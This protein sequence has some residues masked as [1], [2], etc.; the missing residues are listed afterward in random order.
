MHGGPGLLS[1][2]Q[3]LRGMEDNIRQLQANEARR[4][5]SVSD[6]STVTWLTYGGG[7]AYGRFTVNYYGKGEI[8]GHAARSGDSGC[9]WESEEPRRRYALPLRDEFYLKG[10]GYTNEDFAAV[11][12]RTAGRSFATFFSKY[13][14]GTEELDYDAFLRHAGLRLVDGK[15]VDLPEVTTAQRRS[16][17]SWLGE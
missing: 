8:L 1:D 17:R 13:V 4:W 5:V 14:T 10:R 3:Y 9:D 16:R 7:S 15:I 2:E 6:A 11:V 12:A